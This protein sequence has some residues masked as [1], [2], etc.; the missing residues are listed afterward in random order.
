MSHTTT[1]TTTTSSIHP[2]TST[3]HAGRSDRGGGGCSSPS[4]FPWLA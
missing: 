4:P 2:F 1:T 3:R